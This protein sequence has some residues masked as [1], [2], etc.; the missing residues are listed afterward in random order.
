MNVLVA[1]DANNIRRLPNGEHWCAAI[2]PYAFFR[3]YLRVFEQV[4]VATRVQTG[5]VPQDTDGLLRADG[6]GVSFFA[7]PQVRGMKGYLLRYGE[8]RRQARAALEGM[9]CAVI[10]LASVTG[11]LLYDA[12]RRAGLP[13]ALEIVMDPWDAYATN[14][15]ARRLYSRRLRRAAM[16]VNGVAYVTRDALQKKYPARALRQGESDEY[17]TSHY[18]TIDLPDDYFGPPK[19]Y[20]GQAGFRLIYTANN[21]HDRL[22]GHDTLLEA[23][24]Q[25]IR[26]G[27]DISLTLVGDG[28]ARAE[29]EALAQSLGIAA[30]CHFAGYIADG[31]ALRALLLQ[32]DLFVMPSRAEGLSRSLLEAM[33]AGLPCIASPVGGTPELLQPENMPGPEDADA[34]AA[35]IVYF[36]SHPD[37]MAGQSARSLDV[38]SGYRRDVLDARRDAFYR[39]LKSLTEK[40]EGRG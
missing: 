5:G 24:A 34:F 13:I 18:S 37:Y 14:A 20:G 23:V 36:L 39:R 19:V 38:A 6:P 35:R 1:I 21:M 30:R 12:A 27:Y 3:R 33:A 40:R 9:D 26:Q 22:K 8:M 28:R 17:F 10:R 15:I 25:V 32:S 29:F 2:Y 31:A 7:L 11:F 16:A 4:R